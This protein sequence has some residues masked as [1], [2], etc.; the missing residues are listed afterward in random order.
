MADFVDFEAT[1]DNDN[2]DSNTKAKLDANVSDV[3][4]IEDENSFDE[5]V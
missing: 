4:F 3:K 5:C 2:C 1:D